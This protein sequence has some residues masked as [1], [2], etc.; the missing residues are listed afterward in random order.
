MLFSLFAK[1][2]EPIDTTLPMQ[3]P[4]LPKI[5][6]SGFR[7]GID[8]VRIDVAFGETL[9]RTLRQLVDETVAMVMKQH[10]GK[11]QWTQ[12]PKPQGHLLV[13]FQKAYVRTMESAIYQAKNEENEQLVWLA[14]LA[15]LTHLFDFIDERLERKARDLKRLT[16]QGASG[17]HN[18]GKQ[19]DLQNQS[20]WLT[21]HHHRLRDYL[22]AIL[23]QQISTSEWGKIGKLSH[24]LLN[25]MQRDFIKSML[26]NPILHAN[27]PDD[28]WMLVQSYMLPPHADSSNNQE[29]IAL[30][31]QLLDAM[32]M[33][34]HVEELL[35]GCHMGTDD[36]PYDAKNFFPD[37]EKEGLSLD[38]RDMTDNVAQLF[39]AKGTAEMYGVTRSIRDD[40][41][42]KQLQEENNTRV[43]CQ[44]LLLQMIKKEGMQKAIKA[45]FKANSG[46]QAVGGA[47]THRQVYEYFLGGASRRAIRNKIKSMGKVLGD[48]PD[49][50]FKALD[51]VEDPHEG[52]ETLAFRFLST[53]VHYRHDL[54][55]ALLMKKH[56]LRIHIL[57][58]DEDHRLSKA[59]GVLYHFSSD[60]VAVVTDSDIMGHA[61]IKA[62][63]RG[64]VGIT[65][66]LRDKGLNPATHFSRTFFDPISDLLP[67][68]GAEKVFVE[69]DAIILSL[70][71]YSTDTQHMAVA[72][73]CGL[74]R[75]ILRIVET[76]N[77]ENRR[78]NLPV[79]EL[80]IG[81]VYLT[82]A[83]AF[84]FDGDHKITISPAIGRSDRLSSCSKV[85]RPVLEKADDHDPLRHT[86]VFA[87]S[88]DGES[89]ND[90]GE[91]H[92]RYN[93]DGIDLDAPAFMKL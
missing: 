73:A 54:K 13:K 34:I 40:E 24:A 70:M 2:Q 61:I 69:G 83:P 90:K 79:L 4:V 60:E 39:S 74:S 77:V 82:E 68:Y 1:H 27:K 50:L 88:E 49:T 53:F 62:D 9:T 30:I 80:G 37:V 15:I 48:N 32:F 47:L 85:V 63:V 3:N 89:K 26:D 5:D 28:T 91:V 75:E 92:L 78:N 43:G 18:E 58:T 42:K 59:N 65:Q 41:E 66:S 14:R 36:L 81:V 44:R 52:G 29:S 12:P 57:Q 10:E 87:I 20:S 86:D 38:W 56:L 76:N 8:N 55:I 17:R 71:E 6:T 35:A 33:D 72:R 67:A 46:Y 64:S 23:L 45:S 7:R 16:A 25:V 21:R 11:K 51:Q 84:L 31:N 19:V 93:V 22:L